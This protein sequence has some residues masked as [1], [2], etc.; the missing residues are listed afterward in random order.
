MFDA[1]AEAKLGTMLD[2]L[3]TTSTWRHSDSYSK[4][5]LPAASHDFYFDS[6]WD[7]TFERAQANSQREHESNTRKRAHDSLSNPQIS[8]SKGAHSTSPAQVPTA[9]ALPLRK[10]GHSNSSSKTT[11]APDPR[12]AVFSDI[13]SDDDHSTLDPLAS[14]MRLFD[15]TAELAT[16]RP[17]IFEAFPLPILARTPLGDDDASPD[18]DDTVPI[19]SQFGGSIHSPSTRFDSPS[20]RVHITGDFSDT[21]SESFNS[22]M[23]SHLKEM[24]SC[25]NSSRLVMQ[26]LSATTGQAI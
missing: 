8:Q 13:V 19:V 7:L 5:N 17:P 16:Q 22:I 24:L 9:G 4:C 10:N 18:F 14:S 3:F 25:H 15:E 23:L 21:T 12:G 11:P 6:S 2:K 1:K 26:H 20:K